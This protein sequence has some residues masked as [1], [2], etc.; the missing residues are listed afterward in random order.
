MSH[1]YCISSIQLVKANFNGLGPTGNSK[2]G[3]EVSSSSESGSQFADGKRNSFFV[4]VG[5]GIF[6]LLAAHFTDLLRAG[7][8]RC[9]S[10]L[11]AGI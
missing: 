10:F 6:V 11:F 1:S 7:T 5:T 4:G 3:L 9:K 8:C 2:T